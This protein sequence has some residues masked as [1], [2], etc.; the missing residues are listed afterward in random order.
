MNPTQ[1]QQSILDFAVR[2]PANLMITA[3][4]GCGKTSTL[5]MIDGA[6]RKQPHL[7][8]CFNKAIANEATKRMASTTTV[9][10]FNSL[11]HRIWAQ[12]TGSNLKLNTRKCPDIFRALVEDSP[13]S[14]RNEIWAAYDQ[15]LAG[16][17][18]A[19]AHGYIPASHV[20]ASRSLITQSAF[21]EHLDEV[22]DDLCSDLIDAVLSRCIA[23]S[24]AG[25]IDFND[26]VYCPALFG[27]TFP[28]F[29]LV[30]IDE[31][32]DLSPINHAMIGKLCKESRQIGV[33]DDAQAIYAFRG[34]AAG[35]MAE[36]IRRYTMESLSLSVSFRCPWAIVRNVHW[37]VPKFKAIR[38]GG[39]VNSISNYNA[40]DFSDSST[41]ICRNNAPLLRTAFHLL[42]ISKSVS[43]VGTDIGPRLVSTMRKLGPESLTQGQTL[44]AI[45]DWLQAKLDKQSKTAEDYA[46]CMRVFARQAS[47]LSGAIAYAEHLF[48]Q[49][50]TIK[51]MTGHKAKG[52]EFDHVYFLDS[53][54]C[55]RGRGQDSNIDYVI[56][57]RAKESLTYIESDGIKWN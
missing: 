1:E 42:S 52:L 20:Y 27:G 33:G 18:L 25:E 4:A 51:L 34:A 5:E 15:V 14:S 49:D 55:K 57:T 23:R 53:H 30:L 35:G 38:E 10:T 50:G 41:I 11:G 19:R 54:L 24:T 9:R 37:R 16:V 6:V 45:E 28:R 46:E 39:H 40:N 8:L 3:F 2:E 36:A 26:Q 44:S 32:Q 17:N 29:P 43:V 12:H 13:K 21:H 56:S 48:K 47:S 31:Y 7:F 22:P